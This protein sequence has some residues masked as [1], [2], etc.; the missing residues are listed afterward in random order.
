MTTNKEYALSF[1]QEGSCLCGDI[2]YRI[3]DKPLFTHACHCTVCQKITGT[4]YWLSMFVLENDFEIITGELKIVYPPQTYGVAAKHYCGNCGCN[5][6]GTHTYLKGL[7]LPATGTFEDTTWF[8][9]QAHIF[10]RSKQPWVEIPKGA[11]VFEELY[12][13]EQ[14]WPRESLA[15]LNSA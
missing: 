11:P 9:P 13:R 3:T 8:A 4:S 5:I 10:T 1:T 12:D 2:T 14:V 6:Y 7:V 15:R